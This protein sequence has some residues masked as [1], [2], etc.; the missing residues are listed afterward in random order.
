MD[1]VNLKKYIFENKLYQKILENCDCKGFKK[2]GEYLR[3]SIIGKSN[4]AIG[5]SLN[6]YLNIKDFSNSNLSGDLYSFYSIINNLSFGQTIKDIHKILGLEYTFIKNKNT[7]KCIINPLSKLKKWRQNSCNNIMFDDLEIYENN[8]LDEY[9]PLLYQDWI[10][11]DGIMERT[12]QKFNIGFS[13]KNQRIVIPHYHYETGEIVGIIGRTIK[14]LYDE[15]DI[16]KYFPLIKYKKS[17]NIYGLYQN[18]NEIQNNGYV[19]IYESEKSVLKRHSRLDGTG[20]AIGSH[21][22]SKQQ[23]KILKNLNV[24]IIIAFDKDVCMNKI[25]KSC[26]MFFPVSNVSFIYDKINILGGKD[27]PA[28]AMNWD[29]K[30]L[31][32]SRIK[33]TENMNKIYLKG[34]NNG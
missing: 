7:K 1:A 18:Y 25:F 6:D 23:A 3:C 8:I 10:K 13:I 21:S 12:K 14:E 19:V 30:K 4:N 2:S 22:I 33:F 29:F 28:D 27:S 17:H 24:E 9:I 11:L 34:D 16:P 32:D 15:M 5:L 31:F 20:V 26:N